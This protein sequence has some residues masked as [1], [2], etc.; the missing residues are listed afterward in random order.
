MMHLDAALPQWQFRERHW[1]RIAAP[2]Q[3][4]F[5]AIH[6]VTAGEIFL[7]RTLTFIRRLGRRGPESILN[8]PPNEPLLAVATRTGFRY[9]ADDP[10][11]EIVV[12]S[13]IG[14]QI[15]VATNFLIDASLLSTET[16]V[17][18]KTAAARRKFALYWFFIRP[19]SGFI[20]RMWLRAI[21]KRA[22]AP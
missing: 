22:E 4:I 20:R 12:A 15:V 17:F 9:V 19:G 8:P 5:N 16:R 14:P 2:P 10:P 3:R 1:K 6:S 7:F 13:D 11:R 18:A 21:K